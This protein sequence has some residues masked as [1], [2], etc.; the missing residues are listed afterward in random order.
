[1]KLI[2][3]VNIADGLKHDDVIVYNKKTNQ[4]ETTHNDLF[5]AKIRKE[6]QELK[7]QIDNLSKTIESFKKQVNEK[8]KEHHDVL[9]L[10]KGE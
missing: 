3:D 5:F 9:N 1:M 8:F 10:L 2:I 4:W 6:N 7:K